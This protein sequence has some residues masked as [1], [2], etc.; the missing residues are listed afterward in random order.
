VSAAAS[1][2]AHEKI[3]H[4]CLPGVR[5]V[6]AASTSTGSSAGLDSL[7]IALPAAP[8]PANRL[9]KP[10]QAPFESHL[11]A[12]AITRPRLALLSHFSRTSRHRTDHFKPKTG[13]VEFDL[14][15]PEGLP[16]FLVRQTRLIEKPDRLRRREVVPSKHAYMHMPGV[17]NPSMLHLGSGC[18]T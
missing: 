17:A 6:L 15:A 14:V 16:Y 1:P 13:A 7:F 10:N 9:S 5:V 2:L 18:Y 11:I 8:R 4:T 12:L 3:Q